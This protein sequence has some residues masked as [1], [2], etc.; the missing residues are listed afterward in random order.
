MLLLN[1][2]PHI[3]PVRSPRVERHDLIQQLN[4][5]QDYKLA[6]IAAPAGY[7]KTAINLG[8]TCAAISEVQEAVEVLSYAMELSQ[9]IGSA[10]AMFSSFWHL[11][12]LQTTQLLLS[13]AE[14]TCRQLEKVEPMATHQR[15]AH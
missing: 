12:S 7:G 11:A 5:L 14:N 10:F 8:V 3:P 2:K 1:T 9:E 6:L 4:R 15:M 13:D